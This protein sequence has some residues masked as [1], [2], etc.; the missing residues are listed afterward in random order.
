[1]IKACL[2]IYR[3]L[4][5]F[6]TFL[7]VH[8]NSKEV[9]YLSWQNT[10]PHLKTTCH[11]KLQFF[12]WTKL[13]ENLLL[14]KYLIFVTAP[15][16]E[17]FKYFLKFLYLLKVCLLL[18]TIFGPEVISSFSFLIVTG[19]SILTTTGSSSSDLF[20]SCNCFSATLV[21]TLILCLM[22]N[23]QIFSLLKLFKQVV[24]L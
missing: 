5:S 12:L 24:F 22:V 11:I 4:L 6:K 15:W 19:S 10:Y 14:A 7:P 20:N 18:Y 13:L 8:S 2:Q 16:K 17:Q 9:F 1:M 21:C 3:G 23:T